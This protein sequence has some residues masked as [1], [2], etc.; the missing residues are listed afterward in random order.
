LP[1]FA[2]RITIRVS[3]RK[4]DRHGKRPDEN[5]QGKKETEGGFGQAEA[6]VRLQ[7]RATELAEKIGTA[8]AHSLP[9]S[10]HIFAKVPCDP[11]NA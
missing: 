10:L 4:G 3:Q 5:H 11:G 2:L 8:A 9:A 6:N 1:D 7:G